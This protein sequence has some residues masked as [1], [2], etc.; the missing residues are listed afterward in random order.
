MKIG[1]QVRHMDRPDLGVGQIEAIYDDGSCDVRFEDGTFSGVPL[2]C[3]TSVVKERA[4]ETLSNLL[5]RG[6]LDSAKSHFHA[7]CIEYLTEP[8]FHARLEAARVA[9]EQRQLRSRI[10]EYLDAGCFAEADELYRNR[11]SAWWPESEYI[12]DRNR[13]RVPREVVHS[14]RCGS[15]SDMDALFRSDAAVRELGGAD[16]AEL[17]RS[18]LDLWLARIGMQLDC[19]QTAACARPEQHLL[20]KARAGSGKTRTLAA[21]AALTIRD[22]KLDPDQVLTLAFNNKAAKEVGARIRIA[23]GTPD[24]RNARTF[25][26]LAYKL[27]G[28]TGRTLVFDRGNASP[29]RRKQSQF[30]ERSIRSILNPAFKEKLYEFFRREIE[31]IEQI[32]ADLPKESYFAFRRALS[33]VTLSGDP[34]KSNGE[35]FIADFLF[36]HDI[37]FKYERPWSWDKADWIQ[38]T[39]YRPDFSLSVNGRDIILEHWAIDPNDPTDEV[40]AWWDIDTGHYRRQIL[41]KRAWCQRCGVAL[42]ETHTGMLRDGRE[43]FE[44]V[45][46]AELWSAGISCHMLLPEV[47]IERVMAAP[48]RISRLAGLFLQFIQRA[49]KRGWSVERAAESIRSVPDTEPRNRVFHDLALRAYAEYERL[50]EAE[51]AMD[52]D[53]LLAS[54]TE[55]IKRYGAAMRFDTDSEHRHSVALGDLR[56]I[57]LDEYQDFSELYYRMLAAILE[58]NPEIRIVAVGDDW[59]AINGF[60]GA[61]PVF[62]RDFRRYFGQGGVAGIVTNYRSAPRIV[63]AGNWLMGE[64]GEPARAAREATGEIVIRAIDKLFV[65][66]RMTA[67]NAVARVRDAIYFVGTPYAAREPP[68]RTPSSSVLSAAQALRACA[69]FIIDSWQDEN[70]MLK[71]RLVLLLSRT[72]YTYGIQLSEFEERLRCVLSERTSLPNAEIEPFVEVLTAHRAKGKEADSVVVLETTQRQFPKV[73]ADNQL[74]GPFSITVADVLEEE[75]RLFYVAVTRAERRL[76]L[77]TESGQESPY[78]AELGL[79]QWDSRAR[80]L[81][82]LVGV[83][84]QSA[85]PL[86]GLASAIKRTIDGLD[87]WELRKHNLSPCLLPLLSELARSGLPDPEIGHFIRGDDGERC[88]EL[89]WVTGEV[90]VAVLTGAQRAYQHE[91]ERLG[92]V[93]F[94]SEM[95][96]P[97]VVHELRR[98]IGTSPPA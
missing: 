11:C 33:L 29:S 20:I 26:S 83:T 24:Y 31:Q 40:P 75:R 44:S 30:V 5:A 90:K 27:A 34:V 60:A 78:L 96:A 7:S 81:D 79:N 1:E 38:G 37:A 4:L 58:V 66:F 61:Q 47:L 62:F 2:S 43:A 41:E 25:H 88:A 12:A 77:L 54:A 91:W 28:D 32:G 82:G 57:L 63:E 72:G 16:F 45:L 71:P 94:S 3:F 55:N 67:G 65:E 68:P 14:Y 10:L 70:D 89:A 22:Q 13:A 19:E 39:V 93:V 6:E 42:L 53:D 64:R 86:S 73:H 17:K 95:R 21:I 59:Q 56:W 46:G 52:F 87:V 97:T 8:E 18:R 80:G 35:K 98:Y 84:G 85:P 15:L 74:F 92:W 9:W 76:L 48:H 51:S 69:D 36:E 50:L 23:A 49:K